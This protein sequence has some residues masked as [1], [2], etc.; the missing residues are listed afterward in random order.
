MVSKGINPAG[1]IFELITGL[2]NFKYL[3]FLIFSEKRQISA[4]SFSFIEID[5]GTFS[6]V[7][8]AGG[9]RLSES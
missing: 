1:N 5:A 9:V 3:L 7:G 6:R 4:L 2:Q 8:K